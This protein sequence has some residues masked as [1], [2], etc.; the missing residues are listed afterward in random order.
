[1][2]EKGIK[3]NREKAISNY[4]KENRN[5]YRFSQEKNILVLI[6]DAFAAHLLSEVLDTYPHIPQGLDGFTWYKHNISTGNF[7]YNSVNAMVAGPSYILPEINNRNEDILL[8]ELVCKNWANLL[9]V[10]GDYEF[11]LS[12][13]PV[14]CSQPKYIEK[15]LR[16]SANFYDGFGEFPRLMDKVQPDYQFLFHLTL[17]KVSPIR[18]KKKIY[19]GGSWNMSNN[20]NVADYYGMNRDY[21]LLNYLPRNLTYDSPRPTFKYWWFWVNVSPFLIREDGSWITAEDLRQG[22][23]QY[24]DESRKWTIK[25]SLE[26][27]LDIIKAFQDYGIY[28]QTKII[29]ASDHASAEKNW[30]DKALYSLLMV[31]DFQ[32]AG[33]LQISEIPTSNMDIPAMIGT[34][35]DESGNFNVANNFGT[36]YSKNPDMQRILKYHITLQGTDA[37]LANHKKY[38][39]G[40]VISIQGNP[41]D[42]NNWKAQ[43]F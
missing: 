43:E 7:T 33:E 11:D 18:L 2:I 17:F 21:N 23:Q 30:N 35:I 42:K 26:R 3:I 22:F 14:G 19:N 20:A 40:Q 9:N 15:Y 34:G 27:V 13:Y 39:P 29:I 32:E 4:F 37:Y 5:I 28:K 8:A 10:V 36:D 41:Y 6:F 1:N 38:P 24:S 31:K 16:H 25:Y 12:A